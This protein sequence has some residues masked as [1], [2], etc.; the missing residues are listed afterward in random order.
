MIGAGGIGFD[1]SEF[2][3]FSGKATD[4]AD[5][6]DIDEY[7]KEWGVDKTNEARSGMQDAKA[8]P[9]AR[10]VTLLQRKHGKL[11]AGLGKTSGWVHRA[12]LA[13]AEVTMIGGASYDKIDDDGLH[14]TITDKKDKE[15]KTQQVLNVDNVILCAG[16]EP[17]RELEEPLKAAGMKVW[18]IGG[19]EE[20]GELD[21]KKAIDMGTRLAAK[22]EDASEGEVLTMDIGTGAKVI[23][24]FRDVRNK[25]AGINQ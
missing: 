15:K 4:K 1:V 7:L 5:E 19:A 12:Q 16:Q 9:A 14:I 24:F 18:R 13:K 23:E 25:K 17:L 11:G 8:H 2:L 20:A 3:T 10:N 21:A 22:I 6:V